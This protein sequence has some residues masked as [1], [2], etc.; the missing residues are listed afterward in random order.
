MIFLAVTALALAT[1]STVRA[2]SFA[3]Q[4]ISAQGPFGPSLYNDPAS[5]LGAPATNYFDS[6]SAPI[7]RV[8]LNEPV[9]GQNVSDGV[10]NKLI[11]TLNSGSFV[12]VGFD[13]P[14]TNHPA[15]PYGIDFLV[16]GNTF[17]VASTFGDAANLNTTTMFGMAFEEPVLVSVSP[18]FTGQPGENPDDPATWPWYRYDNGPFGDGI[19]PTHAYR[20]NRDEA[21]WTDQL[22]DFT[23]P[24]NPAFE[25]VFAA[26]GISVADAID[27]YTGSGGGAGFDLTPSGFDSVRYVKI[28]ATEEFSSGEIDAIAIVRRMTLGDTL[29]VSPLNIT[30]NNARLFFQELN[31]PDRTAVS[32]SFTELSDLAQ[33]TATAFSAEAMTN[34]VGNVLNSIELNLTNLLH[35][36]PVTFTADVAIGTGAGYGGTG[37]DLRLFQWNDSIWKSIPFTYNPTSRSIIAGSVTNL[38]AFALVQLVAPAMT[39][40]RTATGFR[41]EFDVVPNLLHTLERSTNLIHWT[42]ITNSTPLTSGLV[43]FEDDTAPEPQAFYRLRLTID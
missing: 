17:Y 23:K 14:I 38:G 30:N 25:S 5:I 34:V 4:V 19:F 22:M 27:L 7:T 10:S 41:F 33:V 3:T 32:V 28:E 31:A 29:S 16:F 11:L 8:K 15:N 42:A 40:S 21:G 24:V 26:G 39:I 1:G 2:G 43:S 37:G 18:G 6:A 20:W 13:E 35:S 12:I 36:D 9:W